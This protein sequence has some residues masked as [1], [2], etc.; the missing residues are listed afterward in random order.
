MSAQKSKKSKA[1]TYVLGLFL[2]IGVAGEVAVLYGID[3]PLM[4]LRLGLV[5]LAMIAWP[6]AV[7][8][9]RPSY[10]TTKDPEQSHNRRFYLLRRRVEEFLREVTRLNWLVL[11][12]SRDPRVA[13][14]RSVEIATVKHDLNDLLEEIIRAAGQPGA[15]PVSDAPFKERFSSAFPAIRD[16][17][18]RL[19]IDLG[20]P[21]GTEGPNGKP[22]A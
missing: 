21:D 18:P 19:E 4:R 8:A 17:A 2:L 20:Q 3:D 12:A 22:A 15:K 6:L 5:C 7:T 10:S 11:D 1:L 16:F 9:W 13:E 14:Q